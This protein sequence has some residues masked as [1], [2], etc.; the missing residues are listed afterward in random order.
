ML[1]DAITTDH[2][3][4]NG[5]IRADSPAGQYLQAQGT[6][7]ARLGNFGTPRRGN[8]EICLARMF[9]KPLAE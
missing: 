1:G 6:D 9:D 3:S 5:A 4:P 2:I 8:P 7:P